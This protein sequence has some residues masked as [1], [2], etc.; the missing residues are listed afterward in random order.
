[1]QAVLE[2]GPFYWADQIRNTRLQAAAVA[3]PGPSNQ[4]PL[5]V[6][7]DELWVVYQVTAVADP[8][9]AQ[10]IAIAPS[11]GDEGGRFVELSPQRAAPLAL[12]AGER[13]A[14]PWT[15]PFPWIV[16]PNWRFACTVQQGG[17]GTYNFQTSVIHAALQA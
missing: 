3:A 2:T 1:M 11:V 10:P 9:V 13:L 16:P 8:T 4:T 7:P 17:T 14:V 6:P 5:F 15:A 12:A